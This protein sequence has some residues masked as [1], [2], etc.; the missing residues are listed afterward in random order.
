MER[1]GGR[2]ERESCR[3]LR[4]PDLSGGG[5]GR[6]TRA[7]VHRSHRSRA[8]GGLLMP[9]LYKRAANHWKTPRRFERRQTEQ[10]EESRPLQKRG[11]PRSLKDIIKAKPRR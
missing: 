7:V 11:T 10:E 1:L 5:R 4:P 6:D 3:A 9:H 8:I 2:N